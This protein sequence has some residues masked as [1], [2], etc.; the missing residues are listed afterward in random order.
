MRRLFQA[1][2]D[3]G[4]GGGGVTMRVG[5]RA[6][7]QRWKGAVCVTVYSLGRVLTSPDRHAEITPS[8]NKHTV[9]QPNKGQGRLLSGRHGN[10]WYGLATRWWKHSVCIAR[11]A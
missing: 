9:G 10:S 1:E 11:G 8:V 6:F 7:I 2:A 3:W 4:G 5:V